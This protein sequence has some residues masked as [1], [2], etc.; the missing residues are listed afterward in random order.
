MCYCQT[1]KYKFPLQHLNDII[2]SRAELMTR[3][4]DGFSVTESEVN[5]ASEDVGGNYLVRSGN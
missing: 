2:L 1:K 3:V 4:G 5:A